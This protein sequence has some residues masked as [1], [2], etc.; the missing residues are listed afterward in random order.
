[1]NAYSKAKQLPHL[2]E[3]LVDAH[4]RRIYQ[5]SEYLELV[6]KRLDSGLIDVYIYVSFYRGTSL[7]PEYTLSS[8]LMI[9]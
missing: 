3:F 4:W 8:I 5:G 9:L 2:P 6:E 1:V 7:N